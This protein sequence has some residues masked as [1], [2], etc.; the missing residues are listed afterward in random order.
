MSHKLSWVAATWTGV[1]SSMG[2]V[3]L[4]VATV[5]TLTFSLA[6]SALATSIT[7]S[8]SADFIFPDTP[9]GSTSTQQFTAS[10][11]SPPPDFMFAL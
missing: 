7:V 9:I 2:A 8:P 1:C 5:L 11:F 3:G 4:S 10:L 6:M